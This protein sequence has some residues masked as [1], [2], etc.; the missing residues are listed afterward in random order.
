MSCLTVLCC[1]FRLPVLL[2]EAT[3]P[4]DAGAGTPDSGGAYY[5][6]PRLLDEGDGLQPLGAPCSRTALKNHMQ[7]HACL[8]NTPNSRSKD[9]EIREFDPNQL[10]CLRC[11]MPPDKGKPSNFLTQRL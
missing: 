10:L 9:L 3:L 7:S 6:L 5:C 1:L 4:L 11:K 2:L 8:C